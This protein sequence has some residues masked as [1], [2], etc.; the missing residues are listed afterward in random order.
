MPRVSTAG[1]GRGDWKVA[2]EPFMQAG[3]KT[4]VQRT[5][6]ILGL[7]ALLWLSPA[8][9]AEVS[10]RDNSPTQYTVVE[11]D[12]LWDIAGMFLEEPWLW[13]EVWQINPQIEDPDLIY[14]GDV[15]E[16]AY[17]D[18][19]PVLRLSRGNAPAGSA[20]EG[21]R[22]VRLSPQVRREPIIGT[23]PIPAIPLDVIAAY[24]SG[25][26]VL[27]EEGFE[28]A[29]YILG[30]REGRELMSTGDDALARGTWTS[31]V[32]LYD[33][34]RRGRDL[35]DP[36]SGDALGV[37][38]LLVGTATL[39]RS[40]DDQAS[41]TITSNEQEIRA[42]D[43]LIPRESLGLNASYMP[44]PPPFAVDAAIVS[45]GTGRTIGGTYDTLI[46]NVGAN[47][48][49]AVGQLLTVEDQPEVF[50][51]QIGKRSS[52]QRIKHA[53]GIENSNEVRFPGE[54]AAQVLIYRVFDNA[55]MALVLDSNRDVRLNDRVVTPR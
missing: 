29:P 32:A 7:G 55:S 54:A 8:W 20:P 10:I 21:V 53:F 51:D 46:I 27:S 14:P 2:G 52:W 28:S 48:R 25:N 40:D 50:D 19:N 1:F 36:E 18:G 22:T 30:G 37:E 11:G 44:T 13:P 39:A 42:G 38:G 49:I 12:T 23:S 15:I 3:L 43:R 31:G 16:L 33:I 35:E 41:L 9:A 4:A 26:T 47:D 5:A 24:L 34:I 17:V 6:R 45:I